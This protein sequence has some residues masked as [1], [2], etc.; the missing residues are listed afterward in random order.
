MTVAMRQGIIHLEGSCPS[1]DAEELLQLLLAHA[2]ASVD[3]RTCD[4]AHT[5]VVQVL[6]AAGRAIVGPPRDAV[7]KS[8]VA[9]A[10]SGVKK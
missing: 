10:L 4:A 9:P 1:G 7:L 2:A 5:A 3:L 8:I 6:M